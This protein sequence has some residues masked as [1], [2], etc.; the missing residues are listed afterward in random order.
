MCIESY[1]SL[2]DAYNK[3]VEETGALLDNSTGFLRISP[4]NY[5]NLKSLF[6]VI[7]G[8]SYELNSNAQIWP[9]KLNNIIGGDEDG[10]YLVVD[11]V[12][13]ELYEVSKTGFVA[14]SPFLER[15]YSVYDS[16][17]G[18]IGLAQTQFTYADTN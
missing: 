6:F 1:R 8:I 5:E 13:E 9:R 11:N 18:S 2:L 16:A 12:G 15:F 3:Y 7:G 10:I 14:G 17:D 4:A